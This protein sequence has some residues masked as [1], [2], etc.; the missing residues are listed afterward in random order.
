MTHSDQE[1]I[2]LYCVAEAAPD[3]AALTS[4]VVDL[5]AIAHRDLHAVV[6]NVSELEFNEQA[7]TQNLKNPEWLKPK[8]R[9]HESV[10]EAVM[11]QQT[12][13]PFK[14]ATLFRTEDSLKAC[15]DQ[16]YAVL[17]AALAEFKGR[18]EWRVIIYCQRQKLQEALATQDET[19][20][21]LDA[22]IAK[23]D[24]DTAVL[25]RKQRE[26]TL[27]VLVERKLLDYSQDCFDR[28]SDV[29]LK[30][31]LN[32]PLPGEVT[33][34]HEE[35]ILHAAFFIEAAKHS[36]LMGEGY[37]LKADYEDKGLRLDCTGPWPPYNFCSFAKSSD[38]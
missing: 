23:A 5:R 14:F 10:I 11:R 28:L 3:L 32:P 31:R 22:R 38:S 37:K 34:Q 30:A 1:L 35:M 16:H 7:L 19:L 12:V 8:V 36:V 6:S 27:R 17:K 33:P 25:L 15:L 4:P 2:C 29:S 13:A 26:D 20:Q 21:D 24:Q 18:Q 9:R